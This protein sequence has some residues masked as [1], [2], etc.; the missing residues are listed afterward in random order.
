[1]WSKDVLETFFHL[2][3]FI[4]ALFSWYSL[5]NE[6]NNDYQE[7]IA[8]TSV[9][10]TFLVLLL[11]ILYH[12][13]AYTGLFLKVKN[14]KFGEMIDRLFTDTHPKPKPRQRCYS[15]PSDD[16][17]HRFDDRGLLDELDC[18]V[19]T[20]DYDTTPLLRPP[21]V[22]PTFSVVELPHPCFAPPDPEEANAQNIPPKSTD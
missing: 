6:H 12:V 1:M 16:D 11:I 13:Y 10:I 2:N 18:P 15:P 9:T 7:A 19:Y 8:Y 20:G 4:F 21:Q 5:D 3:I 22:E 17:N 14:T